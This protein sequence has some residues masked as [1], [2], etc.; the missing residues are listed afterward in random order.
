MGQLDTRDLTQFVSELYGAPVSVEWG[1]HR[2]MP[3]GILGQAN[4]YSIQLRSSMAWNNDPQ[5]PQVFLHELAHLL[6]HKGEWKRK[7]DLTHEQVEEEANRFAT[8]LLSELGGNFVLNAMRGGLDDYDW[9]RA[10]LKIMDLAGSKEFR[11][12]QVPQPYVRQ[13]QPDVPVSRVGQRR[14]TVQPRQM[15]QS[16]LQAQGQREMALATKTNNPT[17]AAMIRR[18]AQE[19]LGT[20]PQHGRR[21]GADNNLYEPLERATIRR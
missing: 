20:A 19:K 9:R 5:L 21:S 11:K 18:S 7:F 10:K 4:C 14:S 3:D 1:D 17:V 13:S 6:L 16:Q 2:N 15:T 8:K 12:N